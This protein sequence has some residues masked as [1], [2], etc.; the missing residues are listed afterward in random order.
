MPETCGGGRIRGRRFAGRLARGARRDLA[1]AEACPA[2]AI[3]TRAGGGDADRPGTVGLGGQVAM[4]NQGHEHRVATHQVDPLKRLGLAR[5]GAGCILQDHAAIAD[6]NEPAVVCPERHASPAQIEDLEANG[7]R[8]GER[9]IGRD[10]DERRVL[11]AGG[12]ETA[13]GAAGERDGLAHRDRP[14]DPRRPRFVQDEIVKVRKAAGLAGRVVVE[15]GQADALKRGQLEHH[16][17][18]LAQ[19]G[20]RLAVGAPTEDGLFGVEVAGH[21]QPDTRRGRRGSGGPAVGLVEGLQRDAIGRLDQTDPGVRRIEQRQ[22]GRVARCQT[23]GVEFDRRHALGSQR[24]LGEAVAGH[25]EVGGGQGMQSEHAGLVAQ[26]PACVVGNVIPLPDRVEL[27]SVEVVAADKGR[28]GLL[29]VPRVRLDPGI[30]RFAEIAWQADEREL[31]VPGDRDQGDQAADAAVVLHDDAPPLAGGRVDDAA[32]MQRESAAGIRIAGRD[33]E[34]PLVPAAAGAEAILRGHSQGLA[35]H[36][37][38]DLPGAVE[39]GGPGDHLVGMPA[40]DGGHVVVL[41]FDLVQ[42]MAFAQAGGVH[43]TAAIG[44]D[45]GQFLVQFDDRGAAGAV[46]GVDLA[47]IVEQDGQVV[48]AGQLVACPG[49]V[50]G[51]RTENLRAHAVDIGENVK[52][53]VMVADAGR[54]DALAVDR[55]A[56]EAEPGSEVQTIDAVAGQLPVHQVP[57]VHHDQSRVHVHRRAGQVVVLADADDV[58]VLELFVE[59]RIGIRPVAIVGC[60]GWRRRRGIGRSLRRPGDELAGGQREQA[61]DSGNKSKT[62]HADTP[63]TR[64]WSIEGCEGRD[65]CLVNR[66]AGRRRRKEPTV[67]CGLPLNAGVR[68]SAE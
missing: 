42:V 10:V 54:P 55:S 63:V 35:L 8:G 15:Q 62:R 48:H 13:V 26:R 52:R 2:L 16:A 14:F 45:F 44:E 65:F 53:A 30:G 60:P 37:A 61:G 47:I 7:G 9:R 19:G 23:G 29:Q 39:R 34:G 1:P 46:N 50:G 21:A 38:F 4:I 12:Q 31:V 59:Q 66:Q 5:R 3:G 22:A 56:F 17:E 11:A 57:G 32:L 40:G 20:E 43:R 51:R 41:A 18:R 36:H 28:L 68:S 49:A 33:G 24:P 6:G 67:A 58:G 25:P 27:R 64:D